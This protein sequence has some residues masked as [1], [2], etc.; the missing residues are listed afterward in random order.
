MDY[1]QIKKEFE[2]HKDMIYDYYYEDS[3]P[4]D[5][6]MQSTIKKYGKTALVEME[7]CA[8]LFPNYKST[9]YFI[10]AYG[11][12]AS[13][14]HNNKSKY[15]THCI[16]FLERVFLEHTNISI[17]EN[18]VEQLH[19]LGET[20]IIIESLKDDDLEKNLQNKICRLQLHAELLAC[21]NKPNELSG[22]HLIMNVFYSI[23]DNYII[24]NNDIDQI[25]NILGLEKTVV[26]LC[27]MINSCFAQNDF[28]HRVKKSVNNH[29]KLSNIFSSG[30]DAHE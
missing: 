18:V 13:D 25:I 30:C 1:N 11:M 14:R 6:W 28:K 15:Y 5:D 23:D 27:K 10:E 4:F 22:I 21:F 9:A 7:K 12:I 2:K 8:F 24:N 29:E 17:R 26:I 16:S 19:N 3:H 20:E